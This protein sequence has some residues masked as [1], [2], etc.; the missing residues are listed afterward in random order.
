MPGKT[1]C[2]RWG[3]WNQNQISKVK[4]LST[5]VYT[6]SVL[7]TFIFYFYFF[8]NT[9]V[10]FNLTTAPACNQQNHAAMG[11]P[12]CPFISPSWVLIPADPQAPLLPP[13]GHSDA[14]LPLSQPVPPLCF[15]QVQPTSLIMER[16]WA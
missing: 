7:N 2:T 10:F 9:P 5:Q 12:S 8:T 16:H 11:G 4:I 3:Q 15:Q 6:L 14:D 1:L 13:D